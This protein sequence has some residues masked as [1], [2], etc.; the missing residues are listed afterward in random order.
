MRGF[1]FFFFIW[2][3]FLRWPWAK[4]LLLFRVLM[5]FPLAHLDVPKFWSAFLFFSLLFLLLFL[6]VPLYQ[7]LYLGVTSALPVQM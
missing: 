2:T 6:L 1:F 4:A 3:C 5:V 7:E